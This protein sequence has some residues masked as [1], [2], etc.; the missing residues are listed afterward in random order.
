MKNKIIG[1]LIHIF[2]TELSAIELASKTSTAYAQDGD[3]K[4]DGKYDT[5]GIEAGYLA[6]AQQKRVE[7]L[8]LEL[9]MLE[10]LPVKDFL[11]DEEVALGAVVGIEFKGM[12]RLYFVSSTAGGTMVTVENQTILVISVFSP[13]GDAVMGLKVGEEF[14][15]E[16]PQETRHYK[17][18]SIQ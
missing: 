12:K 14:E 3:V 1:Q 13:V 17:V 7:E 6:S 10:E 15:L 5:R 9:Q 8:K 16:A 4:S 11:Q 2:Q 18:V